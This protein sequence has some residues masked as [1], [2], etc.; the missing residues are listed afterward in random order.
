MY[1]MS[2]ATLANS[3]ATANASGGPATAPSSRPAL[4]STSP[5]QILCI[6]SEES[7]NRRHE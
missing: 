7:M 1:G 5:N 2:S 3:R 6:G 4:S